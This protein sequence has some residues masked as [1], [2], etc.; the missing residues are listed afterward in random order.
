MFVYDIRTGNVSSNQY[1]LAGIN[2]PEIWLRSRRLHNNY[3]VLLY[4]PKISK[5][6]LKCTYAV[7]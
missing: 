4:Q 7:V 6:F 5:S 1:I 2:A 3:K